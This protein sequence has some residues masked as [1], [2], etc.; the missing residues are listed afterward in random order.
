V[1]VEVTD[2]RRYMLPLGTQAQ[3][4]FTVESVDDALIVPS[5]AI[6]TY[7]DDRGVWVRTPPPPG[8]DERYGKKFVRCRVGITDG[9]NTEV[10]A[11]LD[12]ARLEP[13]SEVYVKLPR[14]P[15]NEDE[16]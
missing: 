8:T 7:Q 12:D 15:H 13:G 10:V 3:V 9:E 14:K 16:E 11:V 1:H 4:E 2:A 6:K 5:E